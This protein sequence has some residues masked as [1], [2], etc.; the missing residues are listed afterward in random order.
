MASGRIRWLIL[1][2]LLLACALLCGALRLASPDLGR[3]QAVTL[4]AAA[5]LA[6]WP[7]VAAPLAAGDRATA[8]VALGESLVVCTAMLAAVWL[9]LDLLT[10]LRLVAMLLPMLVSVQLLLAL[11]L[12]PTTLALALA[13]SM[14]APAWLAPASAAAGSQG[15]LAP[16][17]VMLN[18]L[19]A[20]ASACRCDY[21]RSDW[22]YAHSAIGASEFNYPGY[23]V[24]LLACVAIAL[25]LAALSRRARSAPVAGIVQH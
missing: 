14:S 13:L 12:H 20:L 17:S 6:L 16:L 5:L 11:R 3:T 21:L 19:S 7:L 2:A 4:T 25:A 10:A 9:A 22:F 8:P 24:A 18:P 15:R 23:G 1:L